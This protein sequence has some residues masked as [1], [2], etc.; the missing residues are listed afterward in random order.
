M[1][2]SRLR[3]ILGEPAGI[4]AWPAGR[5][6][7]VPARPCGREALMLDA[8]D[9]TSMEVPESIFREELLQVRLS[10]RDRR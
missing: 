7:T 1:H 3:R 6:T 10:S 5:R 2:K 8:A 4:A 9:E